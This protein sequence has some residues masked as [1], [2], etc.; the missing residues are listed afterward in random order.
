MGKEEIPVDLLE[1]LLCP[2]S[3]TVVLF[4]KEAEDGRIADYWPEVGRAWL[5]LYRVARELEEERMGEDDEY[6]KEWFSTRTGQTLLLATRSLMV[7]HKAH[8]VRVFV[9]G[10]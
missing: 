8:Q 10:S 7:L 5:A 4:S 2:L 6:S 3:D 9:S 1:R